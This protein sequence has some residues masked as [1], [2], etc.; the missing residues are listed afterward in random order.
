MSA[1]KNCVFLRSKATKKPVKQNQVHRETAEKERSSGK[2]KTGKEKN[3][4][5]YGKASNFLFSFM[6]LR[7]LCLLSFPKPKFIGVNP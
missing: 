4:G 2:I 6:F 7:F 5:K 1:K 3:G